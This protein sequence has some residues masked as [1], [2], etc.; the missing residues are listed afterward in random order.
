MNR[1]EWEQYIAAAVTADGIEL[2]PELRR[3]IETD[4]EA[5]AYYDELLLLSGR[6]TPLRHIA[7]TADESE[8]LLA[9]IEAEI[10]TV[11]SVTPSFAWSGLLK[12]LW[13]PAMAA[14]LLLIIVLLPQMQKSPEIANVAVTNTVTSVTTD[15]GETELALLLSDN[16]VESLSYL[17]DES[18]QSY[19]TS[20]VEPGQAGDIFEQLSDEELQYL[21]E[22]FTLE[23]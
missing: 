7:I 15:I 14:V 3:V 5:K 2:T 1:R 23:M 8:S 18:T 4:P 10:E 21:A 20:Q 13:Q 12:L 17:L 19:I 6:F 9:G 22:N 16:E 11:A